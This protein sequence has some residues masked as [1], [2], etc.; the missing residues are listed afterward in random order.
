MSIYIYQLLEMLILSNI[1]ISL[2]E[3]KWVVCLV[4]IILTSLLEMLRKQTNIS[5]LTLRRIKLDTLKKTH[6]KVSS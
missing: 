2:H 1:L 4:V 6:S 3:S 5:K